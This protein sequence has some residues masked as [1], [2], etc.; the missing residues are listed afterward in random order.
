LVETL[1]EVVI[2][3]SS[4]MQIVFNNI[5][6]ILESRYIVL[7]F[8]VTNLATFQKLLLFIPVVFCPQNSV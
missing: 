1:G 6:S 4:F 8:F 3:Q 7:F 2:L 5:S